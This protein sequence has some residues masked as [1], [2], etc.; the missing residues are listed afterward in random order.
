MNFKCTT[1]GGSQT[2]SKT[3]QKRLSK[4]EEI[5]AGQMDV[6]E[7]QTIAIRGNH[8]PLRKGARLTGRWHAV[9]VWGVDPRETQRG[10]PI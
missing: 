6:N 7:D 1:T 2:P 9:R 5:T 8:K 10:R 3:L 4:R